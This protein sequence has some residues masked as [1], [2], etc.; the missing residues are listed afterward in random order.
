M[1]AQ[2]NFR[3]LYL[4]IQPAISQ[5]SE[6]EV[7]YFETPPHLGLQSFIFC[8]WQLKTIQPLKNDFSYRVVADGC[9]DILLEI[10]R[11][12]E[13]FVTGLATGHIEFPLGDSFY[14][15]RCSFF[16]DWFSAI[17]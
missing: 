11:P 8:Y 10:N 17:I 4:P 7:V 14:L 3:K 16:T 5:S 13:S 1:S 2:N 12:E 9:I 6:D 15:Y